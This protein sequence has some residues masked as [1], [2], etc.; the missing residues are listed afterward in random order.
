MAASPI[1]PVR[2]LDRNDDAERAEWLRMRALLHPDEDHARETPIVLSGRRPYEVFVAPRGGGVGGGGLCGYIEVGERSDAEG[3]DSSPVPF[4]ESWWVD[5]DARGGGV[6]SALMQA[7]EAWARGRGHREI[8]SDTQHDNALG[9]EVHQALGF[10]VAE[11]LV[12]FRK[13]L[14]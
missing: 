6:G 2:P 11:R 12:A 1:E 14:P 10:E 8:A 5:A 9:I 7:A 4:I 13:D 3:C